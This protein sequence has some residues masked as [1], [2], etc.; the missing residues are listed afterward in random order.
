MINHLPHPHHKHP[1][2]RLLRH[3]WTIPKWIIQ[4]TKAIL[5]GRNLKRCHRMNMRGWIIHST[6]RAIK[7][8]RGT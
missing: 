1:L 7:F 8:F 3:R 2:H 4:G 5:P 6:M